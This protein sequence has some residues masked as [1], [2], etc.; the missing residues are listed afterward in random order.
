MWFMLDKCRLESFGN[1]NPF[2]G[3]NEMPSFN[4][5]IIM[6]RKKNQPQKTIFK[7]VEHNIFFSL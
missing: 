6:K 4:H 7:E 5:M 1:D 3:E 2:C